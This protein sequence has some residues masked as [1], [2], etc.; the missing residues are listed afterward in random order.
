MKG[1]ELNRRYFNEAA[2][3]SFLAR[4]ESDLA[5]LAAGL[6]G[7]GSECFGYDDEISRDHDWGPGFLVLIEDGAFPPACTR[8]RSMV[9]GSAGNLSGLR[10]APR[11]RR[12]ARGAGS[13][14]PLF[15]DVYRPEIQKR[16]HRAS[17]CWQTPK[18]SRSPQ[19]AKCFLDTGGIL[20]DW[21]AALSAYP[22]RRAP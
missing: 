2:R 4:F 7:A 17:G 9:C 6:I 16:P 22:R 20:T 21:R 10:S 18:A 14:R 19:T 15:C 5:Q 12:R 13:A 8:C 11:Q 1:L 3:E